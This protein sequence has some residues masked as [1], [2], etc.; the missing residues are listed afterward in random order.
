MERLKYYEKNIVTE[1]KNVYRMEYSLL[2]QSA[3]GGNCFGVA[4]QKTDAEGNLEKDEVEGLCENRE[5]T[6]RFLF[7]LAEGLALP[8]ELASL[9]DDFISEK[10]F[11]ENMNEMRSA[12]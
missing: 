9:C 5:D 4:V 3:D 6:E 7:R 8:V 11:V 1:E 10:E 12:R 2:M